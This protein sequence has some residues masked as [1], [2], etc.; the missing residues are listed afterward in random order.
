MKTPLLN[1]L[2]TGIATRYMAG[3][4][5]VGLKIAPVLNT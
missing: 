5:A 2:L 4:P 1:P 3:L